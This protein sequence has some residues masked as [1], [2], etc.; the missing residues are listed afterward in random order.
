M[1]NNCMW[2]CTSKRERAKWILGI[3]RKESQEVDRCK[4][5]FGRAANLDDCKEGEEK[6]AQFM[7][8]AAN[9]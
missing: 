2:R 4:P 6:Q 7:I 1:E 3:P 9:W 8:W 5:C